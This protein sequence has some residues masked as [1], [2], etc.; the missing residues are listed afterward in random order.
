M[1]SWI[2]RKDRV[3]RFFLSGGQEIYNQWQGK[4]YF[5]NKV[6]TLVLVFFFPEVGV[7]KI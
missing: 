2:C 3:E 1:S 7:G 6:Q 4:Y 5:Y